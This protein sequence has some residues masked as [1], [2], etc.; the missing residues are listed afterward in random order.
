MTIA[1]YRYFVFLHGLKQGRLGSWA[2]TVYFIGQ[3]KLA[4]HRP[5]DKAKG[6]FAI[7]A[8]FKDFGAKDIGRHQVRGELNALVQKAQY[9]AQC[10]GE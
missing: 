7:R 5:L 3:K 2:G 8:F 10:M 6:A 1:R 4:E 9:F